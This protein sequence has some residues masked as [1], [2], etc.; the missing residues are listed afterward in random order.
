MELLSFIAGVVLLVVVTLDFLFTTIGA[1]TH[2]LLSLRI[3]RAIFA[4]FR[5]CIRHV[6]ARW[7]HQ[8]VGP[9]IMAGI[10]AFWILGVSVGWTLIFGA[11]EGSVTANPG[12]NGT[13]W[14]DRYAH[15]GHLL[16]TLGA[17]QTSPGGTP[18]YVLGVVVAVEGMVILTLAV[19]FILSTTQTVNAGRAFSIL[20][21]TIDAGRGG[22]FD[23]LAPQLAQV[24]SH[25]NASPFALFYSAIDPMRVLP[26]RLVE[27]AERAA[28]GP[29][30]AR[31]RMLLADLPGFAG[32]GG[33]RPAAELDDDRFLAR[34]HDWAA[35]YTLHPAEQVDA[36]RA[37]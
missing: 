19:S 15:A 7:P 23:T 27:F 9:L 3:G 12:W 11:F 10:A 13:G 14:W 26:T 17:G 24:V 37:A 34:L 2:T 36:R 29:D 31:Y 35:A 30:F 1:D 4:V 33:D 20:V 6:S 21:N 5:L 28:E 22:T 32:F 16:S 8:V 18:W 25:L